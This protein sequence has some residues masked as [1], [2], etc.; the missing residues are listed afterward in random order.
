MRKPETMAPKSF[1]YELEKSYYSQRWPERAL[2]YEHLEPYLRSWLDPDSVFT[3]KRVLDIGAGECTYSRLIADRFGPKEVVACELFLERMLPAARTNR[4]PSLKFIAGDCFWLPFQSGSFGVVFG[5][6]VL[7]QIPDIDEIVLEVRRVLS[8]GGCY[9]GIEPNPYHPFHL[10][11]YIRGNHSP[12]QYLLGPRNLRCF[13]K[14]G[15]NIAIRYF[16]AK[17]PRFQN[18][19]VGTCMGI[20]AEKRGG[21]A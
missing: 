9:V 8:K 1:S 20:M 10:Y 14:A 12:N 21:E 11:R 17:L 15:F 13:E 6:L 18:R 19:F 7:H 16:Y 4:N 3:G 5:S 2:P